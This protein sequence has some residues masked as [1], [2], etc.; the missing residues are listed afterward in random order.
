VVTAFFFDSGEF[1][2]EELSLTASKLSDIGF[3]FTFLIAG[4]DQDDNTTITDAVGQAGQGSGEDFESAVDC[5]ITGGEEEMEELSEEFDCDPS[6]IFVQLEDDYITYNSFHIDDKKESYLK[7][8]VKSLQTTSG[9]ILFE[10]D[11]E[12]KVKKVNYEMF[13]EII[14][15]WQQ[16][17]GEGVQLLDAV[18]SFS[19]AVTL[20]NTNTDAEEEHTIEVTDVKITKNNVVIKGTVNGEAKNK[21]TA[22]LKFADDVAF[23]EGASSDLT[24]GNIK[25]NIGKTTYTFSKGLSGLYQVA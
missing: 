24:K 17:E 9:T 16:T 20:V 22:T 6:L 1:E 14:G 5:D 13:L 15:D 19:G 3:S 18:E 21:F 2:E 23:E 25:F 8:G 4:L 11:G 12:A 10:A 7:G